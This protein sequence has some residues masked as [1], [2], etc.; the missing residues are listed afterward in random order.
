[1]RWPISIKTACPCRRSW[2]F[3]PR[4]CWRRRRLAPPATRLRETVAPSNT[5]PA[6]IYWI[7]AGAAA[8]V[9]AALMLLLAPRPRFA[10]EFLGGAAAGPV[11]LRVLA[12]GL[13]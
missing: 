1:M 2:G 9:I 3:I 4:H 6:R 12:E 8:F 5:Q 11:I 13:R 7:A 10:A